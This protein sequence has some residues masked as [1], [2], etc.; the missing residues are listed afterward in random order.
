MGRSPPA[1]GYEPA[2][3]VVKIFDAQVYPDDRPDADF[4][5]L[6][7]FDVERV[8]LCAHAPHPFQTAAD[9]TSYFQHL[10]DVETVRLELLGLVTHVALGIHPEAVPARA[11]YEIWRELPLLL[12]DPRVVALG[13]IGLIEATQR[14]WSLVDKQ[15]RVMAGA[16]VAKPVVFRLPTGAGPRARRAA[17]ERLTEIVDNYAIPRGDILI[18]HVDWL[19]IDAVEDAGFLGGLTTGPL[20]QSTEDAVRIAT[21][22]DRRRLVAGSALRSGGA[23]VLAL[24][25]LA[26]ALSEAGIPRSDIERILYGNA[27]GFYVR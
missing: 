8:L 27:M 22:H 24:P 5:N 7:W 26:V 4:S 2:P 23:D 1:T 17:I 19:T 14:E 12:A 6:H 21:H 15:L 13:E 16:G 18:Q 3:P 25:K 11:H 10:L 20:F 9:L